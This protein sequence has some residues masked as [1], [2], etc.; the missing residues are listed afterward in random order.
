MIGYAIRLENNAFADCFKE[1]RLNTTGGSGIEH[2]K[3]VVSTIM[4][5]LTS[6][7]GG[8]LSHF[9]KIDKSEA[10]IENT[11]LHH[12]LINNHDRPASKGKIKGYVPLEHI[13]GFCKNFKKI[14]K[15]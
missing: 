14:T 3:H 10:E 11:T 7:H 2:N 12:H 15:Q 6:K 9:D 13:C 4:R 1:A 8:L 5:A